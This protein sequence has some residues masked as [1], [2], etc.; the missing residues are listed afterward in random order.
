MLAAT[1]S[2]IVLVLDDWVA[3]G[4]TRNMV[5]ELFDELSG[6]KINLLYGVMRG[7]G[8]DVSGK[9][10]SGALGDWH[11]RPDLIGVDYDAFSLKPHRVDSP[12]A[13]AYRQRMAANISKYVADLRTPV[14]GRR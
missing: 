7:S 14:G 5:R 11:D 12:A 4:G 3:T 9:Q 1:E 13:L 10:D 6:G 2:P 8:A